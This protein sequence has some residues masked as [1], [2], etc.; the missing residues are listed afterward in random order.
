MTHFCCEGELQ[1]FTVFF[2]VE[3]GDKIPQRQTRHEDPVGKVRQSRFV[4]LPPHSRS[5]QVSTPICRFGSLK[6]MGFREQGRTK[7]RK[8]GDDEISAVKHQATYPNRDRQAGSIQATRTLFLTGT[9]FLLYPVVDV[10]HK[11]ICKAESGSF[12]S[13]QDHTV[14]Q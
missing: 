14:N 3:T 9:R 2:D 6:V 5:L 4:C 8:T 7:D 1:A 10:I 12:S 11:T 13:Q